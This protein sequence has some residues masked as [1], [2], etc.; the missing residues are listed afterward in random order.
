MVSSEKFKDRQKITKDLSDCIKEV[1][2][3]VGVCRQSAE[4]A[5]P[6]VS[7]LLGIRC[8]LKHQSSVLMENHPRLLVVVSV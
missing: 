2:N 7:M 4:G 3:L 1:Q 5:E 8:E 6:N